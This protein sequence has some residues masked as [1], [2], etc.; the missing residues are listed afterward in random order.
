ME[1]VT[2]GKE[3]DKWSL[4]SL[5]A[6][7]IWIVINSFVICLTFNLAEE[8]SVP[9]DEFE[10]NAEE[11]N[12]RTRHVSQAKTS[13]TVEEVGSNNDILDIESIDVGPCNKSESQPNGSKRE[14]DD[15]RSDQE[16]PTSFERCIGKFFNDSS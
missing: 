10:K 11:S 2:Y 15:N 12:T 16:Q 5:F 4:I 3:R 7:V 14:S 1:R 13:E 9:K 6:H 8:P